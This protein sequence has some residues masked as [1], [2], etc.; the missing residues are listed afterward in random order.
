MTKYYALYVG[1]K[2]VEM[3]TIKEIAEKIGSTPNSLRCCK[4]KRYINKVK[5]DKRRILIELDD[6]KSL[7]ASEMRVNYTV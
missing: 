5:Y 1:D 6:D 2:F 3:G 7:N 4:H